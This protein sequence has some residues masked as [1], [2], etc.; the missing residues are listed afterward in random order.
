[1]FHEVVKSSWDYDPTLQLNNDA[2][3]RKSVFAATLI[4]DHIAGEIPELLGY[5]QATAANHPESEMWIESK[6]R[7]RATLERMGTWVMVPRSSVPRGHRPIK[8]KFVYRK[9][10]LKDKSLSFK[11]RLVVYSQRAGIVIRRRCKLHFISFPYVTGTPEE[12]H[13]GTVR[14]PSGLSPN[15]SLRELYLDGDPARHVG[16]REAAAR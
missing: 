13:F 3:A 12:L 9:K 5:R 15:R 11:S 8:C 6:G 7:E 10:L 1:M 16:R 4:A 2:V 14:H